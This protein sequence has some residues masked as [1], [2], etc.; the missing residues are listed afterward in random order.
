MCTMHI[1]ALILYKWRPDAPLEVHASLDLNKF[2]YFQRKA[3]R[4]FIKFHS[5]IIVGRTAKGQRQ[6]VSVEQNV[7][8][9][10]CY[11]DSNGLAG[12][13]LADADYPMRVAFTLLSEAMRQFETKIGNK[14]MNV[15]ADTELD[16][17]EGQEL[18]TKFQDPSEA[19]KI[20]KIEKELDEVKGI[21]I[22]SMDDILKRGEALESLMQKSEDLSQVSYQFYRTAKKNNQC[23]QMGS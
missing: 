19:D 6:S 17:P 10:H 23:C 12:A 22:K 1:V 11:V 18:L 2:S 7:G 20:T 21:V 5:R 16:F 15:A 9:C 13:V 3:V 14:W 4:E 8:K